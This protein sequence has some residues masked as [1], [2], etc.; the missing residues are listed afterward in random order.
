MLIVKPEIKQFHNLV[1]SNGTLLEN[2]SEDNEW[3]IT[4]AIYGWNKV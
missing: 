4:G 3:K 1:P 2:N